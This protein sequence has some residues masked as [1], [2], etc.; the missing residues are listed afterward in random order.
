VPRAVV[1]VIKE[2]GGESRL[3]DLRRSDEW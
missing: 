1:E 3:E 2:I